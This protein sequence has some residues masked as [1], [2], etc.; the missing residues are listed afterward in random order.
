MANTTTQ[1]NM[2]AAQNYGPWN[3]GQV[4]LPGPNFSPAAQQAYPSQSQAASGPRSMTATMGVG[5]TVPSINSGYWTN[6]PEA[7]AAQ[8][9][10]I[11]AYQGTQGGTP[12]TAPGGTSP[13]GT[14]G[15]TPGSSNNMNL[16]SNLG[17]MAGAGRGM[18]DPGSDYFQQLASEMQGQIGQSA[19][20]SQRAAALRGAQSGFGGG[21]GGEVMQTAADIGQSGLEAQGQAMANLRLEAPKLGAE[22]L[23]STFG[24]H[25]GMEQLGEGS[26]QFSA[27][28][29]EGARQFGANVGLQQE[30]MAAQR[31]FQEQQ[32]AMQQQQ[33]QQQQQMMKDQMAGQWA[34]SQG[35]PPPWYGGGGTPGG[36]PSTGRQ[37]FSVVAG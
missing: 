26:K 20:A 13:I 25:L 32:F 27:G 17:Y 1:F 21:Q 11:L 9:A 24:T 22:M 15:G 10:K 5:S 18:M 3:Q 4:N 35:A 14:P 8:E 30:Q 19:A 28:L 16:E 37:P 34:M 23:G 31:S 12:G 29:G 33:W 6:N 2:P 7:I 36:A